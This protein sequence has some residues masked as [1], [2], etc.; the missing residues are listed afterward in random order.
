MPEEE[1]YLLTEDELLAQITMLLGGRA[2]EIVSFGVVTTGA[3]SDIE[4]T[5][6]LARKTVVRSM[7]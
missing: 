2:A 7:T 5:I 1:R 6:E 4:N 3:A